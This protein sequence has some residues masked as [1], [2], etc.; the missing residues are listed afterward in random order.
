MPKRNRTLA[1]RI[2]ACVTASRRATRPAMRP[3]GTY[4]LFT[5]A[6]AALISAFGSS[7]AHANSPYGVWI[8]HTG[9][10]G[11]E[12]K[13]CGGELC[14]IVVWARKAADMRRGCGKKLLGG[15]QKVGLAEWDQGWIIAPDSGT[16]YDLAIKP[17]GRNQLE[18]TG[19]AGS[20]LFSKTM[21]WTRAPSNLKRCDDVQDEKK[22]AQ[23]LA[24]A[25][26][27]P[28]Q[29]PRGVGGPNVPLVPETAIE[30][31]SP[32]TGPAHAAR[33][34]PPAVAVTYDPPLSAPPPVRRDPVRVQVA[35]ADPAQ[36]NPLPRVADRVIAAATAAPVPIVAPEPRAVERAAFASADLPQITMVSTRVAD[37]DETAPARPDTQIPC[38]VRAPFV[39]AMIPCQR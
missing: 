19:Y 27:G 11:I 17:L 12:V 10:G 39:V 6:S 34:K 22:P 14:G 38:V 5:T 7:A 31:K 26:E 1:R 2:G 18:I 30:K 20:K 15:L 3:A 24:A 35:M 37:A 13:N 4:A 25:E 16:K 36:E 28:M 21:V 29:A 23:V 33:A 32:V 9:R 8:D